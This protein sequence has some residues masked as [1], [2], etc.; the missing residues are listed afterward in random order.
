[1]KITKTNDGLFAIAEI[2]PAALARLKTI[3][4]SAAYCKG[5]DLK[6][7]GICSDD[8]CCREWTRPLQ[9][10]LVDYRGERNEDL[11]Q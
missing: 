5:C 2:P 7:D 10:A 9:W 8:G 1:M 4:E 3:L 11:L 6:R